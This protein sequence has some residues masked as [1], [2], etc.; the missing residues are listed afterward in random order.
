[1]AAKFLDDAVW[2]PFAEITAGFW[3][4]RCGL[5]PNQLTGISTA[6]GF[7]SAALV[8]ANF[9][10]LATV[11][12]L[13]SYYFDCLDGVVARK[14]SLQTALGAQLDIITDF[15]GNALHTVALLQKPLPLHLHIF[16]LAATVGNTAANIVRMHKDCRKIESANGIADFMYTLIR[17]M[18]TSFN[19]PHQVID[20][21]FGPATYIAAVATVTWLA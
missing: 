14:Y 12:Y 15:A 5:T 11:L 8:A 21:W 6:A 10:A 9:P 17:D 20:D 4:E 18:L 2:Y 13:T 3:H 19:P 7:S 1:M 16:L